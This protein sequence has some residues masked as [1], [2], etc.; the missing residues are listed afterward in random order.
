[1][2]GPEEGEAEDG[3][4]VAEEMPTPGEVR[5]PERSGGGETRFLGWV[6]GG[7]EECPA[8]GPV[9]KWRGTRT[10]RA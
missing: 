6:D 10:R 7:G 1:M 8:G 3:E 5:G 2:T 9:D 4:E